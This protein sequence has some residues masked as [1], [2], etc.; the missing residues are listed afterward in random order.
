MERYSEVIDR[1]KEAHMKG[2]LGEALALY[3]KC[4]VFQPD[5][6]F[7][8]FCMGTCF[9]QAGQFGLS[10]NFLKRVTELKPDLADAWHNLGISYRT[11]GLIDRAEEAYKRELEC[12]LSGKDTAI[13][14]ANW[15]GCYV[16]EGNPERVMELTDLGLRYDEDSCQLKNHRALA[17]LEMGQYQEGFKLYESRY[18]L[19]EFHR[20]EYGSAPKWDGKKVDRLAIHGEQGIGDEILFLTFL[21]QVLELADHVAIECTPRVLGLLRHSYR[22][23]PRIS[24][25]P[26][27]ELLTS[28][29]KA[30]AWCA[31][32][33]LPNY[34]W[35]CVHNVFLE[36]S[37]AYFRSE[38]PRLGISWR[39]G[40]LKTHEYHRN[41]PL[42]FW[43][44]LVERIKGLG[45]DVI[46]L[47]YGPAK[48]MAERLGIPH[49]EDNIQD[50]DML[51][52][53]IKSCD[54]V[55]SVCNSTIHMAGGLGVP[56]LVLVPNKPA[57]RYGLTG[58]KSDWYESVN[59]IRQAKDE[60]WD[61]VLA[62]ATKHTEE[63]AR[64]ANH[65][66]IQKA[67]RAKA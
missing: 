14:Y 36:P 34:V 11:M 65:R 30:D 51:A 62:R 19:P 67:Q 59:Y 2:A 15:S 16:N 9:S 24:V 52:S 6:P 7:L 37:R 13:V 28:A 39:G 54:L 25:F 35:P 64:N 55:L 3:D 46:S 44:P 58:E 1:A 49:D 8:M 12:K 32:G 43:K 20:R 18:R 48:E 47:Q 66:G 23:D 26:T 56:C 5:E 4:L 63:W 27:H 60:G 61:S 41:A 22:N 40:T 17:M 50:L 45:V 29:F 42:D 57:W 10:I 31:M 53:M 38:R 21:K 33:S